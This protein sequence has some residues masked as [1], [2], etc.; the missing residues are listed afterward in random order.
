MDKLKSVISHAIENNS[1]LIAEHYYCDII[2]EPLT[3]EV[4]PY[5]LDGDF[6]VCYR[7]NFV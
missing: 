4:Y 5:K 6:L 2:K 7:N 1:T 3:L